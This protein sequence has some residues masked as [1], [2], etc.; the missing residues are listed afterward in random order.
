MKPSSLIGHVAELHA[1]VLAARQPADRVAAEFFSRRRYIGSRDRRFISE[2]LYGMIRH[3]RMLEAYIRE[4]ARASACP[5]FLTEAPSL[6]QYAAYAIRFQGQPALHVADDLGALWEAFVRTTPCGIFLDALARAEPPEPADPIVRIAVRH[7][8]REFLVAEWVET[9]GEKE[10]DLLCGALNTPAQTVV[11]VNTLR[12]TREECRAALD[13]E[14]IASV[15]TGISPVG[16]QL[17][18]R[19]HAPSLAT[20]RSGMFEVQDEASQIAGYVA[21]PAPG[22]KVLD[23]CAGGGG[24]TLHAA[25]LMQNRGMVAAWDLSRARLGDIRQR[26]ERA[27]VTIADVRTAAPELQEPKEDSGTMDLVLVDAPCSG[28]GTFR[29]NPAEKLHLTPERCRG[30]EDAQRSILRAAARHVR[31]GGRLLYCTCTLRRAENE[32]VVEEFLAGNAAYHLQSAGESL[33]RSG[34]TLPE[35]GP[36]LRLLP[37]RDRTDGFFAA[38]LR[39]A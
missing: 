4:A 20:F 2:T 37:H 27:G 10:A 25:A 21:A 24:K 31:P 11:R 30:Y 14:K 28:T 15:P 8:L 38:L 22:E 18:R 23:Y 26:L 12:T 34:I 1:G 39:H 3:S 32:A 33:R 5:P 13:A 17:D 36:Y 19:F 35:D 9:Y 7:S 6:V 29:R 16:L